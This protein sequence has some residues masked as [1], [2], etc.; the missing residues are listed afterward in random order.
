VLLLAPTIGVFAL[1]GS[2]RS[3]SVRIC[4]KNFTEQ[5]LLGEIMAQVIEGRTD[6]AVDRRFG[7]GGT[8][9]CHNALTAGE[10]DVYP[11]YT[12]TALTAILGEEVV[13]GQG[14]G[15][16][17]VYE[18]VRESYLERFDLRW[19]RPFGFDN[20]YVLMARRRAADSLGW[21]TVTDVARLAPSLSV[22]FTAEFAERP[23]G[24][25]GFSAHYGFEFGETRDLEPGIL[26]QAVADDRVD[27]A[28]G[29]AT[30]GR[31]DSNDL[32]V[33]EDDQAFFPP[34]EAA[35]V[36]RVTTLRAYPEL[37]DALAVLGGALPDSTMRRMNREAEEG[38]SAIR[39][40]AADF[41]ASRSLLAETDPSSS[42][43]P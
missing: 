3:D 9:I 28:F 14:V 40:V 26:Y 34:Y 10:V 20:T 24:Y 19:L 17:G 43:R 35:P 16:E 37:R 15:P 32:V 2:P 23:D 18:A 39:E 22:G 12:G 38:A 7:L 42:T 29:F 4:T 31:I 33:L 27:L 21:A 13:S 8:I 30:D 5:I 25:P 11:E 41:L 36:A 1:G 6:L